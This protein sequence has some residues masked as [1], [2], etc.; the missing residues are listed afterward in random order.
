L[1]TEGQPVT[2][3]LYERL[4]PEHVAEVEQR[5]LDAPEL[6]GHP[7]IPADPVAKR[8]FV[9]HYGAYLGVTS[10]LERTGLTAAEPPEHVHAMARGA[11]AA[12]GGLYE[13]DMVV[14]ALHSA[15]VDIAQAGSGLD[16]GCSSGR[17]LRVLAA[18]WPEIRWSGCDPNQLAV[19]WAQEQFPAISFFSNAQQPPLPIDEGAL[20]LAYAISIWSHFAEALGLRWFDEMH[21]I[22]RPGGHLVLTTHGPQSVAFYVEQGMRAPAQARDITESLYRHGFWYAAE[23]GQAGDAGVVNPEWGTAFLTAEWLLTK[24]CPRWRVVE[25]APGRNQRNQ[26]VYVLQ[27]A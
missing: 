21:R 26:D 22:I 3:L 1:H 10:V 19:E 6:A 12:G 2:R 4:A 14:S 27:R 7:G 5:A 20:G 13:A 17:V 9:L 8:E 16:F 23:F 25:Y 24:L 18:A 11:L 15:G